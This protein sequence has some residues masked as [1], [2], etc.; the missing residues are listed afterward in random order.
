LPLISGSAGC[1]L[2]RFIR[3]VVSAIGG[4][5]FIPYN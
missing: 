1:R 3:G 4:L 2:P 5:S